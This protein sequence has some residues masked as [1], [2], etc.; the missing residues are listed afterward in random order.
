MGGLLARSDAFRHSDLVKTFHGTL[1]DKYKIVKL[2]GAG[3]QGKAYLVKTKDTG[4]KFVAKEAREK[5]D[6]AIS[7]LMQEFERM[8]SLHH[9]NITT[10][11]EL[12]LD[13]GLVNGHWREQIFV[14]TELAA[15]Q[16]LLKYITKMHEFDTDVTETWVAGVFKQVLSG[17]AY[18][19]GLEI[20][21]N[22]LKPENIL[23]MESFKPT[24][25]GR[26][27]WVS[28]ND[29][30]CAKVVQDS[31]FIA[32]DPRYQSPESLRAFSATLR[33]EMAD[34]L[35]SKVSLKADIWSMGSML[36]ELLSGGLIP[37]LY[38]PCNL[39]E[40]MADPHKWE[41]LKNSVF[42][43]DLE[44]SPYLHSIS[45]AA[46]ALLQQMLCK[47]PS[48]RPAAA[49]A[50]QDNWFC[51]LHD[52]VIGQTLLAK[53]ELKMS[54]GRAHT[55]LLN[56]LATKLKRDHYEESW[57]FFQLVDADNSG[58]IDLEELR[59]VLASTP[60]SRSE[61]AED[62]FRLADV[63]KEGK[64][65]FHEFMAVTFDWTAL[66]GSALEQSLRKLFDHLDH[67]S[68]GQVTVEEFGS[69][70]KGAVDHDGVQKAFNRID[71]SQSGYVTVA[72]MRK[73]LFEP[74]SEA[75]V[76]DR[77]A[78]RKTSSLARR[79]RRQ[80]V[81]ACMQGVCSICFYWLKP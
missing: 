81:P 70:F 60:S 57:I 19:H 64:L 14:I 69:L 9:P 80:R 30:G 75:D 3:T 48:G 79:S 54:K 50:L 8:K 10:V 38:E 13:R 21:H 42:N 78:V 27:P 56:A 77:E 63:T 74:L 7:E 33:G 31:R 12:V 51:S 4:A 58:C 68:N 49:S 76:A 45:D 47:D 40:V 62:F 66:D 17:V 46:R 44:F 65:N 23:C 55:I 22:D 43:V 34:H 15:G 61:K 20:I 11:V 71:T 18:L 36:Y 32:G 41:T 73:F 52:R 16:D 53:L 1:G 72:E 5:T 26:V 59:K 6:V 35:I 28:I 37:F 39:D 25:P 67:D 29:F 2:I 24:A